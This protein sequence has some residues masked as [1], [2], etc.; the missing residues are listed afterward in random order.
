MDYSLPS[1]SFELTYSSGGQQ[2]ACTS[3]D[4]EDDNILEGN[5]KFSVAITS[6]SLSSD[7]IGI[8]VSSVIITIQDNEGKNNT[9]I[10]HYFP[11]KCIHSSDLIVNIDCFFRC[12]CHT[13]TNC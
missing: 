4:I 8:Q 3:I 12:H 1:P 10:C 9:L 13:S 6:T 2:E 5:Q 11:S 7:A